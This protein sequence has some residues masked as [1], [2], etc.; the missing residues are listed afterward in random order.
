MAITQSEPSEK[1]RDSVYHVENG[2]EPNTAATKDEIIGFEGDAQ[3]MEDGYYSS[4]R[5]WGS[6]VAIG[7]STVFVLSKIKC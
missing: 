1:A 5:F 3:N 7:L 2:A 4:T 6:M